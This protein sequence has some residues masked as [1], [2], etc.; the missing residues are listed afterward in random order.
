[1]KKLSLLT[2]LLVSKLILAQTPA[3]IKDSIDSYINKGLKDWDV[4]G[5][6]VVIVKDGKVVLMK[7]YGVK[8]IKTLSPVDENTLFMIASNTKLFTGTA[9]A[10]LET[11][12]KISLDDKVTKYF[13]FYRLYDSLKLDGKNSIL[14][15]VILHQPFSI[16]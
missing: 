4:P 16:V 5:L 1:M 6:S 2:C 9:L 15:I 14:D 8:D 3:F 10:L 13:P 7:G 11:R 12:G